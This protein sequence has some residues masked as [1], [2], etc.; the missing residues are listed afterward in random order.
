MLKA[1]KLI[2]SIYKAGI[3]SSLFS[4]K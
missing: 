3:M 2:I 1:Y 4:Y